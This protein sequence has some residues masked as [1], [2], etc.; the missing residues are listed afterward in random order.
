MKVVFLEQVEG[1]AYPG[2]VKDV[3]DG[4]ARNYLLPRRLAVPAN[5]ATL[6]RAQSLSKKEERRQDKL[7]EEAQGTLS[8]LEGQVL[9]FEERVGE[10]GRLYGSVTVSHIADRLSEV[11]GQD[12]DRHKVLLPDSLRQLGR[13]DVRLRLSRN[14]EATVRVEV[15]GTGGEEAPVIEATPE[16]LA[17]DTPVAEAP[18]EAAGTEAPD[19]TAELEDAEVADADED[20]ED[21]EA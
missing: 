20:E 8:K 2:E 17:A 19:V 21:A 18:I 1:T 10:Q 6:E 11:L 7:D 16:A 12:F 5:A 15:V 13:Y 9:R 4:F 3:A 14:V